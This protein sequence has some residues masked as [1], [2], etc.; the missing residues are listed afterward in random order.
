[1]LR[2]IFAE[3]RCSQ[4]SITRC[5]SLITFFF[6]PSVFQWS[7][8]VFVDE[9]SNGRKPPQQHTHKYTRLVYF[10]RYFF[11]PATTDTHFH[12]PVHA[13][14]DHTHSLTR[15]HTFVRLYTRTPAGAAALR[16]RPVH[17]GLLRRPR[18]QRS[19]QAGAAAARS[20]WGGAGR[21]G[22]GSA[23]PLERWRRHCGGGEDE[24]GLRP[25]VGRVRVGCGKPSR[26]ESVPLGMT[27]R[28]Q[29]HTRLGVSVGER[30]RDKY[31][32]VITIS[33]R[34]DE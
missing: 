7:P 1:M 21:W 2:F 11:W 9:H 33:S 17:R 29:T 4:P 30:G 12:Q 25:R 8:C 19:G 22:G 23:S 20:G 18:P 10:L 31:V 28:R 26:V 24:E 32:K 16:E 14:K 5:G 13:K 34:L 6:I 3:S 27:D 15:T